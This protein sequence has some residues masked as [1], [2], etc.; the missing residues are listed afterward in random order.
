MLARLTTTGLLTGLGLDEA[1][2]WENATRQSESCSTTNSFNNWEIQSRYLKQLN[3]FCGQ[4]IAQFF[5]EFQPRKRCILFSNFYAKMA[6]GASQNTY[7]CNKL[8][9]QD[10]D[11]CANH[12]LILMNDV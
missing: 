11:H 1:G 10:M 7:I 5:A 12:K 8:H 9:L 4:E 2:L 6:S 3:I